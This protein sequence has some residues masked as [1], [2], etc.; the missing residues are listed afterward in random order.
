MIWSDWN[1]RI[2]RSFLMGRPRMIACAI[3]LLLVGIVH[4]SFVPERAPAIT[5]LG[6]ELPL[7][8]N[9]WRIEAILFGPRPIGA[10]PAARLQLQSGPH[11]S[12]PAGAN[13]SSE[14]QSEDHDHG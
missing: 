9:Q 14:T 8:Y 10:A 7:V 1:C 3:L 13:I 2:L 6:S 11:I 12:R 5:V 4:G